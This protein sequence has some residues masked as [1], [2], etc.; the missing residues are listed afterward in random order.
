MPRDELSVLEPQVRHGSAGCVPRPVKP[1]VT[2]TAAPAEAVTPVAPAVE[3]VAPPTPTPAVE[4][5]PVAMT[6]PAP[7]EPVIPPAAEPKADPGWRVVDTSTLDRAFGT[8]SSFARTESVSDAWHVI[9]APADLPAVTPDWN[10]V[11]V[12]G[13]LTPT[14]PEAEALAEL[15]K[16]SIKTVV[17]NA[18]IWA[19]V[20]T[21]IFA[22]IE[23]VAIHH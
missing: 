6:A 12:P 15:S 10:V 21:A 2:Y 22:A 16:T 1:K 20:L 18:A 13:V 19:T 17:I 14:T 23:A 4:M 11:D 7:A 9:G 5:P 3:A 8:K